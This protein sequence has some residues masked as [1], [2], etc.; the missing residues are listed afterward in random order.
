VWVVGN[1][2]M[3]DG[4]EARDTALKSEGHTERVGYERSTERTDCDRL[5][6]CYGRQ[7]QQMPT[8]L[9]LPPH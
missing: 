8:S 5:S 9:S 3:F 4:R 1:Y 2:I 7:Y 6:N